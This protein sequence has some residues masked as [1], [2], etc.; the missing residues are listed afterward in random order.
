MSF[1]EKSGHNDYLRRLAFSL[2]GSRLLSIGMDRSA[3]LWDLQSGES[4]ALPPLELGAWLPTN[5]LITSLQSTL[6]VLK[7]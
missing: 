4:R 5:T 1:G 6:S 7:Y 3:R 2:D